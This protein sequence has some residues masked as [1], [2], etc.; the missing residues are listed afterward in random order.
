MSAAA[1]TKSLSP[2]TNLFVGWVV[3]T[4]TLMV[5]GCS[6]TTN[7]TIANCGPGTVLKDGVC[8]VAEDGAV[9][10]TAADAA[11]TS[12]VDAPI[13]SSTDS[14]ADTVTDSTSADPC[15]TSPPTFVDCSG[16][17]GGAKGVCDDRTCLKLGS[18]PVASMTKTAWTLRTPDRPGINAS[19][20]KCGTSA[21]Y[22]I[23]FGFDTSTLV[24][25]AVKV[26]ARVAPPWH[27]A[28]SD[29]GCPLKGPALQCL[30]YNGGYVVY[31]DDPNAPARNVYIE[32]IKFEDGCP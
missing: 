13:E 27:V 20:S 2:P 3:A 14:F 8:V 5:A 21:V 6:S 4:M 15:P 1:P 26:R 11:D 29:Y 25:P 32:P 7:N 17:C 23:T 18:P 31:T 28:E 30:V 19:C 9:A 24:F 10:D 16:M 12:P 22:A